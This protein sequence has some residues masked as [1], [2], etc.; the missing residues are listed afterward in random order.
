[1]YGDNQA[2]SDIAAAGADIEQAICRRGISVPQFTRSVGESVSID[3]D[4]IYGIGAVGDAGRGLEFIAWLGRTRI[5]AYDDASFHAQGLAVVVA[6]HDC[7]DSE[8]TTICA[9]GDDDGIGVS[10]VVVAD[11]H[12][13]CTSC[14]GSKC[15]VDKAACTAV[16][17]RYCAGDVSDNRRTSCGS[18]VAIKSFYQLARKAGEARAKSSSC[19]VVGAHHASRRGHFKSLGMSR[20]EGCPQDEGE[21]KQPD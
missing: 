13:N 1:M 15:F 11:Y 12:S 6:E 14:L 2:G 5:I 10:H 20:R 19:I 17:Q 16:N 7:R 8:L 3:G 4:G 9:T 21:G 18:A